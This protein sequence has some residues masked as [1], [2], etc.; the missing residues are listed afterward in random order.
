[1]LYNSE[2]D[3]ISNTIVATLDLHQVHVAPV[4]YAEDVRENPNFDISIDAIP[5][6]TSGKSG[7][8]YP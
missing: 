8:G 3:S 1:M 6:E 4:L 2:T 7:Y 5:S